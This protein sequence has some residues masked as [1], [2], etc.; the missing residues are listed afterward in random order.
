MQCQT[1]EPHQMSRALGQVYRMIFNTQYAMA[2]TAAMTVTDTPT[3]KKFGCLRMAAVLGPK[4]AWG[5]DNNRRELL[6]QRFSLRHDPLTVCL[7]TGCGIA[8]ANT[9]DEVTS[10]FGAMNAPYPGSTKIG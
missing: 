5:P 3:S 4:G 7:P 9:P 1:Q 10:V 6:L 2:S 8:S